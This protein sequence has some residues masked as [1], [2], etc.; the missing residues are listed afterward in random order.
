VAPTSMAIA[1]VCVPF[2]AFAPRLTVLTG[3]PRGFHLRGTFT[4]GTGSNGIA[5]LTEDVKLRVGTFSITIP[6]GSFTQDGGG[7]FKFEEVIAGV[8]LEVE[9]EDLGGRSFEFKV[10]GEGAN[11]TGTVNPV[12]VGLTIG[13]DCGTAVITAQFA[14]SESN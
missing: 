8:T 4:L 3:P 2:S 12:T 6:A 13:N 1:S 11:L 10:E 9:I 7:Q 14:E 5:P